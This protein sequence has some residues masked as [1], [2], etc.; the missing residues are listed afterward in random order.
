MTC[1][2]GTNRRGGAAKPR[3]PANILPVTT[4]VGHG[5]C[6]ERKWRGGEGDDH[7]GEGMIAADSLYGH[8]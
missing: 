5:Q 2:V 3:H 1:I 6:E 8:R 7:N 4:Q